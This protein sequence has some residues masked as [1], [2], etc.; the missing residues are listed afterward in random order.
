LAQAYCWGSGS[1]I[2]SMLGH[3]LMDVGRFAYWWT[4]IAGDF[5]PLPIT[6]T[7]VD[8]P[9]LI[10]CAAFAI[11]LFIVLFAILRL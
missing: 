1:L 9:F 8:Q 4:G 5:A 10:A 6:N 3:V 11:S 2:P 7:G